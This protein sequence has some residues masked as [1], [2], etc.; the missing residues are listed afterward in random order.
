[1]EW[2]KL[3]E[4]YGFSD[5]NLL[6]QK[7]IYEFLINNNISESRKLI[8]K[9]SKLSW[10]KGSKYSLVFLDLYDKEY[11][12]AKNRMK[13]ILKK[14]QFRYESRTVEQVID[15]MDDVLDK[16]EDRYEFLYWQSLLYY[17]KIE[18][19]PMAYKKINNYIIKKWNNNFEF[20][21][22]NPFMLSKELERK[23][24]VH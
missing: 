6:V 22:Y 3:S 17:H 10:D 16:Y 12:R 4:F 8:K 11:R 14:R 18:N 1:M 15:F 7:W 9:S 13:E 24:D 5:A 20:E 2:N 23:M 19:I 21:I